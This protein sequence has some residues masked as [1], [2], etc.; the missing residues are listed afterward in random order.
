MFATTLVVKL[1][2]VCYVTPFFK[3]LGTVLNVWNSKTDTRLTAC[4]MG[5]PATKKVLKTSLDFIDAR[6]D[7]V[8]VASA[9]PHASHL[10]RFRQMTMPAPHHSVFDRPDAL[11]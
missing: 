9:G 3:N 6:D 1:S 8:A 10:H 5:N 11:P 4:C 7:G 2:Y